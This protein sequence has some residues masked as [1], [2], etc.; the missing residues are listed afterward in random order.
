MQRLSWILLPALLLAAG[1]LYAVGTGQD[2]ETA[3]SEE[4][5]RATGR[6]I[7]AGGCFWC[8]ES[9]LEQLDGVEEVISGYTGGRTRNPTYQEVSAGGTGHA[10]AVEVHYD[11][12]KVSYTRILEVFRTNIDP[13]D[14]GGQFV[15]RGSQYRSEIFYLDE[16][17]KTLAEDSKRKLAASGHFD[18]PLV[19]GIT[20]AGAFYPA[21]EYHQDYYAKNPL[22]Y[23]FYTS[24]SGRKAYI[25]KTWGKQGN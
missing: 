20:R 22:R 1:N 23:L 4:P 2:V 17:Q 10:E 5:S 6:A 12:Q 19:T 8:M 11:P 21:E 16:E 3:M 7:L 13:T 18:K 9:A 15:D 25:E 24:G 14:A